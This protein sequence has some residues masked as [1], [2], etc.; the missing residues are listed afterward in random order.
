MSNSLVCPGDAC[1][2]RLTCLRFHAWLDNEDDDNE[3]EI[4]PDYANGKC[5]YYLQKEFYGQ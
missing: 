2:L 3:M 4:T 5:H 1:P